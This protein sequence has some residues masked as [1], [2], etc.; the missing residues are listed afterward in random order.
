MGMNA[1]DQVITRN[2][3]VYNAD[4]MDVMR[5][6]PPE[7]IHLSIYSPPFGGL[8]NYSSDE[9]DMSNCRDYDHFSSTTNSWFRRSLVSP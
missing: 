3:A 2:Y 5:A 9:R 6:L 7:S 4:C 1:K 8:Y